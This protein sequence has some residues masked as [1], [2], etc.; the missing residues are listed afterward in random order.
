MNGIIN[1][2]IFTNNWDQSPTVYTKSFSSFKL[3]DYLQGTWDYN[4]KIASICT[5]PGTY[6]PAL[7]ELIKAYKKYPAIA[8]KEGFIWSSTFADAT[9][10]WAYDGHKVKALD[11]AKDAAHVI[12][13]LACKKNNISFN[14]EIDVLCIKP[15]QISGGD[16]TKFK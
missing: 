6:I 8:K 15:A 11:F 5:G 12:S 4:A 13:M 14:K 3:N 9:H 1:T 10:L 7:G 16:L 2:L